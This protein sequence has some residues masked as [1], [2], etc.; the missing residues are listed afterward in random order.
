MGFFEIGRSTTS[1]T[2]PGLGTLDQT[3]ENVAGSFDRYHVGNLGEFGDYG[4]D[5]RGLIGRCQA[6]RFRGEQPEIGYQPSTPLD[7]G[8]PLRLNG[9]NASNVAVERRAESN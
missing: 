3:S 4:G 9:P 1:M 6:A 7:A 8:N 2:I 5:Y